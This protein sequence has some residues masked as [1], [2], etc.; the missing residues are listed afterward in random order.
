MRISIDP[1]L[2]I[3]PPNASE[4]DKTLTFRLSGLLRRIIQQINTVSEGGVVGTSNATTAAPTTGTWQQGD[5]IKNSAPTE[6]GTAGSKYI[7]S[8]WV[9]VA[10][11]T[12]GTWEQCRWLTGN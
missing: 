1:S 11:G 12:P 5:F 6:L 10:A 4:Y 3:P 9:V 7:I 2:P 8:G